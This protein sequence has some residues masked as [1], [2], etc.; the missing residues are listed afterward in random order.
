MDRDRGGQGELKNCAPPRSTLDVYTQAITPA[1]HMQP[2][3]PF[4]R[5]CFRAKRI[6]SHNPPRQVKLQREDNLQ[7]D[8]KINRKRDTKKGHENV[9]FWVRE[10]SIKLEQVV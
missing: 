1:K 9:P 3:Q 8:E 5:W 7:T 10:V 4:C 2:R 6:Q